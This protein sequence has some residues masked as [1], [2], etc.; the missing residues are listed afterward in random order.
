MLLQS[1]VGFQLGL[2]SQPEAETYRL[3]LLSS[4]SAQG[5]GGRTSAL[6]G[7]FKNK[8]NNHFPFSTVNIYSLG[9]S[10]QM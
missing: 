4:R 10:G 8:P 6:P 1:P 5:F 3:V 9:F 2:K 7:S